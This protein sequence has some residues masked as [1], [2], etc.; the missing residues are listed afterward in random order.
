MTRKPNDVAA[1]AEKIA[2]LPTLEPVE[3]ARRARSLTDEAK[4]TLSA[5]G[6]DAVAEALSSATYAEVASALG[7]SA[8]A[9]NK[10]V[11]RSRQR[12]KPA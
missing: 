11:T 7:V 9:V 3:R 5:V 10:A 1:L 6:D 8:S 4:S 12:G 2:G